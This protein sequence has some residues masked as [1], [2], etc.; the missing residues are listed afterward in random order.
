MMPLL[1]GATEF[2]REETKHR[3]QLM[4]EVESSKP[5]DLTHEEVTAHFAALGERLELT[6]VATNRD[7]FV[8]GGLRAAQWLANQKPGRYGIADVLGLH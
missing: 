6:H 4:A 8:H 2:V 1:T 5:E 3:E 7:T